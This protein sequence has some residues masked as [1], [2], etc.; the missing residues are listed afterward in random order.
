MSEEPKPQETPPI[1]MEGTLRFPC[2]GSMHVVKG[3]K[4]T[5]VRCPECQRCYDLSLIEVIPGSEI[6][7][8]DREL[9]VTKE[10]KTK[11]G[12]GEVVLEKGTIVKAGSDYHGMLGTLEG[13]TL[14]QVECK[15]ARKFGGKERTL[16]APVPNSNL[17]PVKENEDVDEDDSGEL[18]D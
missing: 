8:R 4:I 16:L 10:T 9:R 14:V 5:Q 2:C 7:E 1:E 6:W 11:A 12:S 3:K 15:A 17:E 13:E 18:P